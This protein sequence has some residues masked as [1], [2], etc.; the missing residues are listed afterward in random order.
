[1]DGASHVGLRESDR[2][3]EEVDLILVGVLPDDLLEDLFE[4][5]LIDLVAEEG[6]DL[7]QEDDE[8]D[9]GHDR[10]RSRQVFLEHEPESSLAALLSQDRGQ[11][12]D[13]LHSTVLEQ[14][15]DEREQ[16]RVEVVPLVEV[17]EWDLCTV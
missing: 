13:V 2:F 5:G 4:G 1:M 10:H 7:A 3:L 14:V 9:S 15:V 17:S 8:L 12:R 16:L 6:V 11:N